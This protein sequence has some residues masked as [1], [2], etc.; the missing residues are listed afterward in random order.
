MILEEWPVQAVIGKVDKYGKVRFTSEVLSAFKGSR[1]ATIEIIA[2]SISA[3]VSGMVYLPS[4]QT[5]T[6]TRN[7]VNTSIT[8]NMIEIAPGD[9]LTLASPQLMKIVPR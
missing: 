5:V 7:D 4:M 2:S 1:R 9:I 8:S 6:L 3:E